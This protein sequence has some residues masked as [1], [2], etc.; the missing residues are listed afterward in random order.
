MCWLLCELGVTIR[1]RRIN[2]LLTRFMAGE[3]E[4]LQDIPSPSRVPNLIPD[5]FYWCGN[6]TGSCGG[7]KEAGMKVYKLKSS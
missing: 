6:E 7:S 2:E 1:L 4:L 3:G 5:A